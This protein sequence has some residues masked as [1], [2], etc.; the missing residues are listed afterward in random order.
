MLQIIPT[1]EG[2]SV[3]PR[4]EV[5]VPEHDWICET[6]GAR[7]PHGTWNVYA[8]LKH[9]GK[10]YVEVHRNWHEDVIVST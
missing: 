3:S 6:C 2:F 8:G 9:P 1:P 10:S 4:R 5:Q 7:V